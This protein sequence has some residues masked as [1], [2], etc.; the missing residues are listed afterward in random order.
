M[1]AEIYENLAKTLCYPDENTVS[2]VRN[3]I[4]E[5]NQIG[6][7]FNETFGPYLTYLETENRE[8]LEEGYTGTFDVQAVCPLEVGYALFGEDY[9]R[10]EF[11][12]RMSGLHKEY[13]SNLI[14]SELADYL[15]NI[16]MLLAK[17]P[18]GEFKKDLIE[19][20][21]MPAIA[22]MIS[23]FDQ[24]KEVN[25]FSRPIR[26]LNQLLA[27]EYKMNTKILEVRHE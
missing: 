14:T 25:P 11:L 13:N 3:L 7:E 24:S 12:V 17:M 22:R 16:L 8:K 15:P 27:T 10:G 9:K 20:I 18:E 1:K 19:K 23:T 6:P 4:Q 26:V 2:I 5:F 21:L